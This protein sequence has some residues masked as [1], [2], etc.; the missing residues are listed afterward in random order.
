M[1]TI[2]KTIQEKRD[3][4]KEIS[5]VARQLVEDGKYDKINDAIIDMFYRN[6]DHK[7]FNTFWQ[8]VGRGFKVKKGETAFCVWAKFLSVQKADK[9]EPMD[10]ETKDFYPICFLF[11]NAQ[12]EERTSK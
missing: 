1:E 8:W 3:L 5:G 11:S 9:G 2:K 6:G 4:L 7:E 12:V 10:E